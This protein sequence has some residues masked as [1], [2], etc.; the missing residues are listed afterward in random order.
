MPEAT[1]RS[2][3]AS[4]SIIEA[5][6]NYRRRGFSVIPIIA[7]DKKPMV[8]WEPY[9]KE[10]A[11]EGTINHWFISWPNANVAIVTGA[12]SDCVVI[13]LD[14][15]E[16]KDEIKAL[17]P[18]DDLSAVPRVR[19]GR[20][21]YHL[22]FKHPGV[23]IQTRAGVLPKTD[24][25]GDGGYVVTA[26]SIHESGKSYKW[27]VPLNGEL[28]NLPAKLFKLISSPSPA[29]VSPNGYREKFDTAQALAGVPEGRRDE[30]LFKLACKLRN[31]GVPRD[32]AETLILEAAKNCEPPFSQSAALDKVARVYSKF[33]EGEQKHQ[34]EKNQRELWPQFLTAKDILQAP[35][36]PTRWIVDGCLPTAGGSIVVAKPKI[37]KSTTVADLSL[38]VGRGEPFL[39]RATQQGPVAYLFL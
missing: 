27:E 31:A 12:I 21:G 7:K 37:G 34:G 6:I 8:Q 38:C 23:N 1:D 36:D 11:S 39:G 33:S 22:F 18:D 16:A 26:P 25:R 3:H 13:D 2:K 20:G 28:P 15:A 29:T 24:V 4:H 9:Q 17:V 30:T 35:K 5:A 14:T 32:M 10:L 19:T